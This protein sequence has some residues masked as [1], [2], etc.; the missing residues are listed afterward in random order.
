MKR[1]IYLACPYSHP[2]QLVRELR[3]EQVDAK[4]AE[5]MK[6]G[7]LVF[8]PLSHSHPISKYVDAERNASHEFWLEQDY[9]ILDICDEVRVLCLEG[10]VDS[11][12]VSAEIAR[13]KE[14][15][16]NIVYDYYI[17][18]QRI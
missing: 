11:Y 15:G 18:G 10:W 13:A 1:K 2:S 7:N 16:M 17:Q 5:L 12:G 6:K 14:L 9:W 4:A 3:T 8:S